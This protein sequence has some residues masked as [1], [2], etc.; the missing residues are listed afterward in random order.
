[1]TSNDLRAVALELHLKMNCNVVALSG[2]RPLLEWKIFQTKMQSEWN[3]GTMNW[4]EATGLARVCGINDL[5]ALDFD[6]VSDEDAVLGLINDLG[7]NTNYAWIVASGS[8]AGFHV[9]FTLKGDREVLYDLCGSSGGVL[10]L[11]PNAVEG[12]SPYEHLEVRLKNCYTAIPPSVHPDT[13][14]KY[15]FTN[16]TSERVLAEI[17]VDVLANAIKKNCILKEPVEKG[18]ALKGAGEI[19]IDTIN[20]REA[21]SDALVYIAEHIGDACYQEWVD[22]GLALASC[23]DAGREYFML[24]SKSNKEYSDSDAD[25]NKKFDGFLKD[26]D[27]RLHLGT[28]FH[29]AGQMGWVRKA[30]KFWYLSGDKLKLDK[31][32]FVSF[33]R[34]KG[35]YKWYMGKDPIFIRLT[36]KVVEEVNTSEIKDFVFNYVR[37][38][39]P[40]QVEPGVTDRKIESE[41]MNQVFVFFSD[42]FLETMW[43]KDLI[44]QRDTADKFYFYF[45][46][47]FVEVSV[48]NIVIKPYTELGGYIWKESISQRDFKKGT[49]EGDFKRFTRNI[50]RRRIDKPSA[51][52]VRESEKRHEAFM[53]MYGYVLHHFK[54]PSIT[55]A[56]I[57]IDEKLSS[58]AA[59]GTGKSIVGN[60][61]QYLRKWQS[62]DGKNFD[63]KK[64]FAF[65]NVNVGDQVLLYNDVP[66]YF[67]FERLFNMI[68]DDWKTEKKFKSSITIK[69]E[70]APKILLTS[71]YMIK[72]SDTST[73]RRQLLFA[74]TDYYNAHWQPI[75]DFGKPFFGS[76]WSSED[77]NAFFNFAIECAMLYLQMGLVEY[78]FEN[79]K[80]K[81]LVMETNEDFAEFITDY[82]WTEP[83]I[84]VELV[85]LFQSKYKGYDNIATNKFGKWIETYARIEGLEYDKNMRV[86]GE[87]VY[88]VGASSRLRSMNGGDRASAALSQ[89]VAGDQQS[90]PW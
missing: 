50:C 42:K 51:E 64:G 71:N 60:S 22:V 2:K 24:F 41:L 47:C 31:L 56:V 6:K 1:M 30:T 66:K 14:R 3:I 25:I 62:E 12:N 19:R 76:E 87:R 73:F 54:N 80:Y 79:V 11:K 13:N 34:D 40:A 20:D 82:E 68:T 17:S 21:L 36:G 29:M 28:I 5:C 37:N 83:V 67:D 90:L 49:S 9:W 16:P 74:L 53:T 81:K 7:L 59:G 35:F 44:F 26:Y 61:F 43:K 39:M 70:D 57:L 52:E 38:E 89:E 65:Q 55:K 58:G 75:D 33:L 72:G 77:W 4:N 63:F 84:K 45:A 23:G 15:Y 27:G 86:H 18:K 69:A 88:W 10:K 8:G 78:A 46:N 85:K 32:K 48:S